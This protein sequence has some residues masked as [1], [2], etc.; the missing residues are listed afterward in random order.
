MV[1]RSMRNGSRSG[2]RI[3][4]KESVVGIEGFLF[5]FSLLV[6]LY[7]KASYDFETA[8]T[9]C[10]VLIPSKRTSILLSCFPISH[11]SYQYHLRPTP[12]V[13][14]Q[15]TPYCYNS[16]VVNRGIH[17]SL[18]VLATVPDRYFGSGS[19]SKPH[20]CQ[21]GGPGR[22]YTRTAHADTVPW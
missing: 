12:P 19:R 22:Q 9:S 15:W 20:S 4:Y 8:S 7:S 6:L 16:H 13:T 17:Q 5:L 18:V 1:Y 3:I 10:L 14:L 2:R 11:S 21:I